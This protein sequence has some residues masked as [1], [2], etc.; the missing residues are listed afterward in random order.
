MPFS[1][2]HF[3]DEEL[4]NDTTLED[5][6][7]QAINLY[8]V[9]AAFFV[10]VIQKMALSEYEDC[11]HLVKEQYEMSQFP[12]KPNE[13][14]I[15]DCLCHFLDTC[16]PELVVTREFTDTAGTTNAFTP[17]FKSRR[18]I[19]IYQKTNP[20]SVAEVCVVRDD[21]EEDSD[22][23]LTLEAKRNA[24]VDC[25]KYQLLANMEI[26]ATKIAK[27]ILCDKKPIEQIVVYGALLD[28]NANTATMLFLNMNFI[29][30]IST[31]E[32]SRQTLSISQALSILISKI[33]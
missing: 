16:Y 27:R 19:S 13:N 23:D 22:I 28:Y 18:D 20:F 26:T 30:H 8:V 6:S 4:K 9:P 1:D 2:I 33:E 15:S 25:G 21:E 24:V 12:W 7:L 10:D 3:S 29:E 17:F 11:H 5:I 32:Q 31:V 14:Q